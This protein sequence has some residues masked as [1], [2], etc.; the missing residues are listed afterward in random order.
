MT[1]SKTA[2]FWDLVNG[3]P[4]RITLRPDQS[5]SWSQRSAT[6]E[7]WSAEFCTWTFENGRVIAECGTDGVDCDGRMS[8]FTTVECRVFRLNKGL[9]DTVCADV[10][11]P[12]W[13]SVDESQRDY[14]AEA[15][16]Y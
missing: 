1:T 5:L 4:V 6:D 14:S 12:A 10:T 2:R 7:G 15:M 11:Y 8:H 16:G 13:Q 3:S 9:R